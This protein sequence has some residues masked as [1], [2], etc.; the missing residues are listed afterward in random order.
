MTIFHLPWW[1]RQPEVK[2]TCADY[3]QQFHDSLS[4]EI[5]RTPPPPSRDPDFWRKMYESVLND[6]NA[7]A[8]ER[9]TMNTC[10]HGTA[11]GTPCGQCADELLS[12]ARNFPTTSTVDV[13]NI[14]TELARLQSLLATPNLSQAN[15]DEINAQI[16][17]LLAQKR[18]EKKKGEVWLDGK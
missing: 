14:D 7:L 13:T 2:K 15:V 12:A 11:T 6:Y 3:L 5:K 10:K 8:K 9:L 4:D 18:G 16:G 1:N 17:A